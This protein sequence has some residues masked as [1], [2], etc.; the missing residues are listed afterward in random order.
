MYHQNIYTVTSNPG[1]QS[2][3]P[4]FFQWSILQ[5][6]CFK[7]HEKAGAKTRRKTSSSYYSYKNTKVL[8]WSPILWSQK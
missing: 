2:L 4:C 8:L 6:S 1:T 7:K 3:K 5:T